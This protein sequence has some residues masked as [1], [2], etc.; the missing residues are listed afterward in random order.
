MTSTTALQEFS[1]KH[2]QYP[3][4]LRSIYQP[5]QTLFVNGTIPKGT[6]IAIVGSRRPTEYGRSIAYRFAY[7]LARAGL[8]IV[9][10][11]AYGIDSIV[12]QAVLDAGGTTVAV[13]GS[14]LD[15]IYPRVHTPLAQRIILSGGAVL[16]EYPAGTPGLPHHFPARNRIIAGLSEAIIVPEADARSGSL[17]TASLGL[18]ENRTILAI[19]GPITSP[20]SAGPNN[21]L[22]A[23]AF[24]VT[25]PAEVCEILG[26]T[27]P[28]NQALEPGKTK[29]QTSILQELQTKA[30]TSDQIA[31][32]LKTPIPQL[33]GQL[34]QLEIDGRITNI[35]AQT[36]QLVG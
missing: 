3:E 16:S 17:I 27:P 23:G 31:I 8:I 18:Q 24:P 25:E 21:L 10:G 11:L 2:K 36:W 12:H 30:L 20:R 7:D 33:L 26:V 29:L 4:L 22:K 34:T 1:L 35:G 14:G 19:P 32:K 15:S 9:S 13:I 28:P 5:P 6:M